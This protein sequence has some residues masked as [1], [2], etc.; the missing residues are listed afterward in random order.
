MVI[1]TFVEG[2][3]REAIEGGFVREPERGLQTAVVSY[4]ANSL[5]P[6]TIITLN[7]SPETKVG[8]IIAKD[9]ENVTILLSTNK[10]FKV[11][12][13]KF[14][15]FVC[16]EK[17]A[18]SRANVLYTQKTKGIVPS[19]IDGLYNERVFNRNQYVEHKK[20]LAKLTPNTDE[21][22]DTKAKMERADTIQYVIKILLNSIY[23][24]FA[25]KFSPICDSDHAGSITLTG[26]AVVKQ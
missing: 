11:S 2:P 17:L 13:E 26:Q 18:I 7:I 10:E 12:K 1:P 25:N 22:K 4:D 23:G 21:Y 20:H 15:Q 5:Y 6:N 14:V 24:V 19:L 9:D 8:K 16:N 3:T